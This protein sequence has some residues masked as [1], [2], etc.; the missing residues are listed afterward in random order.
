MA[1]LWRQ[2]P[3]LI[4]AFGVVRFLRRQRSREQGGT[5]LVISIVMVALNVVVMSSWMGALW[6]ATGKWADWVDF[7]Q[8]WSFLPPSPPHTHHKRGI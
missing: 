6:V 7:D 5:I 1:N 3:R 8:H 4:R 2:V